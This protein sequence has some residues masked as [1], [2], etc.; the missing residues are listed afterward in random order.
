MLK[1][2]SQLLNDDWL[3]DHHDYY[4]S[5]YYTSGDGAM[6]WWLD[7]DDSDDTVSHPT[8][9]G[10]S[11]HR[12]AN[13]LLNIDYLYYGHIMSSAA[14]AT[15]GFL[16]VG[17]HFHQHLAATQYVAPLMADFDLNITTRSSIRYCNQETRFTVEWTNVH[18]RDKPSDGNFTFQV[19]IFNDSRIVFVYKQ[20]PIALSEISENIHPVKVGISDAYYFDIPLEQ[21]KVKRQIFQYHAVVLD[22]TKVVSNSAILLQPLPTC[23]IYST[24]ES[25]VSSDIGFN[26]S[27]C[28][29]LQ[30]CSS[31]FDRH[32]QLWVENGCDNQTSNTICTSA[33]K[34]PTSKNKVTEP[35]KKPPQVTVAIPTES[36]KTSVSPSSQ[37][38]TVH[39][40]GTSVNTRIAISVVIAVLIFILIVG[41]VMWVCYAY[42]YPTTKSGMCL[43]ELQRNHLSRNNSRDVKYKYQPQLDVMKPVQSG[44]DQPGTDPTTPMWM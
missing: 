5:T 43:L 1:T 26:C 29:R 41:P 24:C 22:E 34:K 17:S 44:S 25:C 36:Y 4:T 28:S 15:G 40:S 23:N 11:G 6:Q 30:R 13:V 27:W 18:L 31:G 32:R 16:Y 39:V 7:L 3:L 35:Q 12:A 42:R 20:I 19:T 2:P 33:S 38:V 10:A 21:N 8:L 9:S 37:V 14:I